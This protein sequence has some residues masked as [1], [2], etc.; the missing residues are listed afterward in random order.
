MITPKK[1]PTGESANQLVNYFV[2]RGQTMKIACGTALLVMGILLCSGC[3][4]SVNAPGRSKLDSELLVYAMQGAIPDN[5]LA[6]FRDEYGVSVRFNRYISQD[7]AVK[8]IQKGQA[9]DLAIMDTAMIPALVQQ[10]LVTTIHLKNTSNSNVLKP[11]NG[12]QANPGDPKDEYSVPYRPG[13]M[14]LVI[15]ANSAHKTTAEVFIHF[16]LRQEI[17]TTGGNRNAVSQQ[18]LVNAH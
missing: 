4:P 14:G 1:R 8:N 13:K 15:L 16:L 2:L 18:A 11:S 9:Y 17:S 12:P 5:L 6:S 7:E 10:G 3:A